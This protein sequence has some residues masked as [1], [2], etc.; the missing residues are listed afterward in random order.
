MQANAH[1]NENRPCVGLLKSA[2]IGRNEAPWVGYMLTRRPGRHVEVS[3][4]I[5]CVGAATSTLILT[6]LSTASGPNLS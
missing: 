1:L 2:P 4:G 5:A 3:N 6:D